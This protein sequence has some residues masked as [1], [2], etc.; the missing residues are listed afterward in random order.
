MTAVAFLPD[1]K[2]V[3]AA[4]D[5]DIHIWPLPLPVS[6]DVDRLRLRLQVW[7]GMELRDVVDYQTLAPETWLERKQKLEGAKTKP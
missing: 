5:G 1:G 2:S 3:A 4:S 6:D 7:T